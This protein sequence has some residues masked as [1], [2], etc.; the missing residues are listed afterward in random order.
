MCGDE[1]A[2]LIAIERKKCVK[3]N[4]NEEKSDIWWPKVSVGKETV[5]GAEEQFHQRTNM[6]RLA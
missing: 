4:P 5:W 1:A 3:R 6:M 2:L